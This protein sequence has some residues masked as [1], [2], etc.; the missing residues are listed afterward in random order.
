MLLSQQ[1]PRL[2][3]HSCCPWGRVTKAA[4]LDFLIWLLLCVSLPPYLFV[5]GSHCVTQASPELLVLLPQLPKYW[6]FS[7]M[8]Q[9]RDLV[10]DTLPNPSPSVSTETLQA[11]GTQQ[12][13]SLV[14]QVLIAILHRNLVLLSLLPASSSLHPFIHRFLK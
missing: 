9:F 4:A 14:H 8:P 1:T 7:H 13:L 5:E 6:D 10:V 11:L 2:S 3:L 12:Q